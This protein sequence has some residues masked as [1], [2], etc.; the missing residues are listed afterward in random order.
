VRFDP[1]PIAA[2]FWHLA[3]T[4]ENFPRNLQHAVSLALPL[5]IV[6][7]PALS[8]AAIEQWLAAHGLT[9]GLRTEPRALR[10]CL[11]AHRGH[12]FLFADGTMASD[13]TRVTIGHE[14]AHFLRH[15]WNPRQA[16]VDRL[17]ESVL[18]ALDGDRAPTGAERLAGVLRGVS[19]GVCTRLLDRDQWG[20]PVGAA[21]EAEA[22][23]D[24]IAFELLAPGALVLSTTTPGLHRRQTLTDRF[25]LPTW[26]AEAWGG[27]LDSIGRTDSLITGLRAAR[28]PG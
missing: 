18:A 28:K 11:V 5:T 26:A 14:T 19:V 6:Y 20:V 13:E 17:G 22:E 1:R 15:Y 16:A 25:G 4:E 27:W 21:E 24:L 10:G 9:W 3:G 23:A 8:P 12:G 7:L 2:Q